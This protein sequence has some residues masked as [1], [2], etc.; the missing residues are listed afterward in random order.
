MP[1]RNQSVQSCTR[2]GAVIDHFIHFQ[3]T[4]FQFVF[5]RYWFRAF[6]TTEENWVSRNITNEELERSREGF[7]A[8]NSDLMIKTRS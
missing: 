2:N 7:K 1:L 6:F 8:T 3:Q 5:P 4:V